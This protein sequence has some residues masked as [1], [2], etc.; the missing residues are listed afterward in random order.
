[1]VLVAKSGI[2]VEEIAGGT[3]LNGCSI[4]GRV[5]AKYPASVPAG[6]VTLV[7]EEREEGYSLG[8]TLVPPPARRRRFE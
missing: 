7:V 6:A 3:L 5:E 4:T 2:Q 1:M 8:A